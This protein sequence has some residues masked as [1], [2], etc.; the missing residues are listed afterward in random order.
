MMNDL[1]SSNPPAAACPPEK[2]NQKSSI[3]QKF[4]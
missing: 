2:G 4:V 3:P 1:I